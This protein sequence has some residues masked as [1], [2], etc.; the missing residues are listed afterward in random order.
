[1]G[2]SNKHIQILIAIFQ[3][4]PYHLKGAIDGVVYDDLF[5]V[6]DIPQYLSDLADRKDFY[7]YSSL[8]K[9]GA[10]GISN[11]IHNHSQ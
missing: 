4:L 9:S 1:M 10:D 6:K 2:M 5:E 8:L 11:L 3:A 7:P